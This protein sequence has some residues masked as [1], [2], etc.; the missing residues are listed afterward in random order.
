[1]GK[2]KSAGQAQVMEIDKIIDRAVQKSISAIEKKDDE[3]DARIFDYYKATE[4]ILYNYPKLIDIVENEQ[5]YMESVFKKRSKSITHYS[6]NASYV[7]SLEEKEMERHK[8][9]DRTKSQLE[10]LERV[11]KPFTTDTRFRIIEMYYFNYNEKGLRR[12]GDS[13][14]FTFE[15][16]AELLKK[17]DGTHPDEKTVRR[18][19][20]QIVGEISVALFGKSAALSNSLTRRKM[21]QKMSD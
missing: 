14:K 2:S 19:R 8:S 13:K 5:D 3:K 4:M 20:S 1:M 18:W 12:G 16:I 9:Y 21:P 17:E 10:G 15:Q 11:L 7:D 6:P